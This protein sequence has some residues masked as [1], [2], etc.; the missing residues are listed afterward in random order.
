MS[1]VVL[2]DAFKQSFKIFRENIREIKYKG[3]VGKKKVKENKK[4]IKS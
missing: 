1:H 3:K 2:L 4:E